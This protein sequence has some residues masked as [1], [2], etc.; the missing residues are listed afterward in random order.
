LNIDF[1]DDKLQFAQVIPIRVG[2][3]GKLKVHRFLGQID[4]VTKQKSAI[5]KPKIKI[6]VNKSQFE[7]QPSTITSPLDFKHHGS[8]SIINSKSIIIIAA[9]TGGPRMIVDLI[10]QFPPQFPPV[11][12]IQHMPEGFLEPFADRIDAYTEMTAQLAREGEEVN[13]N[14]VY[15]APGGKHLEIERTSGGRIVM[16]TNR[17]DKINFVRP[18]ADVTLASVSPIFKKGTIAIILTGMGVD[19]R[20]GCKMVKKFGGKV[21]ALDE[22]DSVIYGMNK[23]VI[24]AGL[25]DEVVR[26]N[27]ITD[28]LAKWVYKKDN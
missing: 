26:I 15:V 3:L 12:V 4:Q 14:N 28:Q 20:E 10:S 21:M 6:K 18:A 5:F 17:T 16:H 27:Q 13:P 23:S 19:G 9:S 1:E 11:I 24:E 22:A 8:R 7:K 2:I 25:A